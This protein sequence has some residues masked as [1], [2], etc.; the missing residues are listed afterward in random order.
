M[1]QIFTL[2][3]ALLVAVSALAVNPLG[4]PA[5]AI[6]SGS[7]VMKEMTAQVRTLPGGAAKAPSK[8][9]IPTVPDHDWSEWTDKGQGTLSLDSGMEDWLGMPEYTGDF[10]GK[11]MLWRYDK[12]DRAIQQFTIKGVFNNVD[13]VIDWDEHTLVSSMGLQSTGIDMDGVGV[14]VIDLASAYRLFEVE[15]MTADER[16]ESAQYYQTYNYYIKELDR[17]YIY[18]AIVLEGTTE[19]AGLID[20]QFQGANAVDCMPVISV[21]RYMPANVESVTFGIGMGEGAS[22]VRYQAYNGFY[23]KEMISDIV[24]GPDIME[25]TAANPAVTVAAPGTPGIGTI[26]AVT[27]N[28]LG[29]PLEMDFA[30]FNRIATDNTGWT[31]KGT[32]T[33]KSDFLESLFDIAASE[34]KVT[35]EENDTVPGLYRVINP[36]ATVDYP[37]NDGEA[38]FDSTFDHHMIIDATDPNGVLMPPFDPGLTWNFASGMTHFMYMSE[39]S[40]Q[41]QVEGKTDLATLK[42]K[43]LVGKLSDGVITFP[44]GG[45]RIHS[46]NWGEFDGATGAI[47]GCGAGNFALTLPTTGTDGV[48]NVSIN[49]TTAAPVYYNLQGIRVEN[50]APGQLLIERRGNTALKVVK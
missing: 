35:V 28:A 39:G 13:L 10:K 5:T 27:Y 6:G 36:Y 2:V 17:H 33:L 18:L 23:N 50:P 29:Q 4:R 8:I 19:A 45:L 30:N 48:D 21:D 3:S 31:N 26:M 32:G 40:Y 49:A 12:N 41:M 46:N 43:G 25:V 42:R 34:V 37:L 11:T 38:D 22:K 14:Q 1:K 47:Y 7:S 15:G 9:V 16:E 24:A 20:M 44:M